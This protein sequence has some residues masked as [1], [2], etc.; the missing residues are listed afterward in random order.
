MA[1][2]AGLA[3]P[4]ELD[5]QRRARGAQEDLTVDVRDALS[6]TPGSGVARGAEDEVEGSAGKETLR[7]RVV[8]PAG[9]NVRS[10]LLAREHREPRGRGHDEE[11]QRPPHRQGVPGTARI[12]SSASCSGL[13]SLGASVM[14]SEPFCV[15]GKGMTSRRLSAPESS[16]ERRSMPSAIPP[17]GGAPKRRASRRK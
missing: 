8:E 9:V 2:V 6:V 7:V 5:R 11:G 15:F 12:L 17:W 14:R 4:A 16:I 10:L 1:A 3:R 13:T